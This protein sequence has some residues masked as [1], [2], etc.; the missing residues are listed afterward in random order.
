MA[1]PTQATEVGNAVLRIDDGP[2][3]P[4]GF[5]DYCEIIFDRPQGTTRTNLGAAHTKRARAPPHVEIRGEGPVMDLIGAKEANTPILANRPTK[6]AADTRR[7]ERC[8]IV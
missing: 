5:R 1:I 7:P 2:A 4:N 8:V 6:A 3:D